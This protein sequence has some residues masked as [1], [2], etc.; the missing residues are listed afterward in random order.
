VC[1]FPG[2]CKSASCDAV[3]ECTVPVKWNLADRSRYKKAR[4]FKY[5]GYAIFL[6][7]VK[8]HPV[9]QPLNAQSQQNE[10]WQAGQDSRIQDAAKEKGPHMGPRGL[11]RVCQL[12]GGCKSPSCDASTKCT[13]PAGRSR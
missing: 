3:T 10:T 1:Q 9:M 11:Y 7:D 6:E 8:K 5:S 4:C 12:S 2:G 13:V